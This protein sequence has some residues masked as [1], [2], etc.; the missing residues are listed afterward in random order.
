[1]LKPSINRPN[2][3]IRNKLK[4]GGGGTN[5]HKITANRVH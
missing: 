2:S 1:M 3:F 4:L 5:L